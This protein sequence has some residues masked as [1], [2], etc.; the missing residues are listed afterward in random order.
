MSHNAQGLTALGKRIQQGPGPPPHSGLPPPP[1]FGPAPPMAPT[2]PMAP[3]APPQ[4]PDFPADFKRDGAAMKAPA[5]DIIP[6]D[7][8]PKRSTVDPRDTSIHCSSF[9]DC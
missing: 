1:P 7:D 9:D 4:T 5:D 2:P 8:A 3:P 6:G